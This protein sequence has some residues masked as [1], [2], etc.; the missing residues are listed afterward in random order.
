MIMSSDL[1]RKS[2]LSKP[3]CAGSTN[4]LQP[5]AEPC[6]QAGR[7]CDQQPGIPRCARSK[8]G[9]VPDIAHRILL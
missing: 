7:G 9:E 6:H 5:P 4:P 3:C 1:A 8:I 2:F